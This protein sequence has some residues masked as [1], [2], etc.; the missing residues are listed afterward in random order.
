MD[1]KCPTTVL[2]LRTFSNKT[3]HYTMQCITC[4]SYGNWIKR[5]DAEKL[6]AG[7]ERVEPFDTERQQN[8][9]TFIKHVAAAEQEEEKAT[10]RTEYDKYLASPEWALKRRQVFNRCRG[11]CEGCQTKHA[12]EVHHLNYNNFGNELLF[13]LVGL[14][15]G[16]HRLAH[17]EKGGD[18]E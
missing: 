3:N 2:T 9:R 1:C 8:Y 6:I 15:S 14:C 10:L 4:G 11:L 17:P 13:E 18:H 7:G 16:C 5:E 12:S